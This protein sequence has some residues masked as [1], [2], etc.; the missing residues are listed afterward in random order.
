L[1][2]LRSES[3]SNFDLNIGEAGSKPLNRKTHELQWWWKYYFGVKHNRNVTVSNSCQHN[4]LLAFH[5]FM[6][7]FLAWFKFDLEFLLFFEFSMVVN[8]S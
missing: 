3:R 5:F 2:S 7:L 6:I 8:S 4:T 1:S